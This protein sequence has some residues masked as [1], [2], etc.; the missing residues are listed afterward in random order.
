MPSSDHDLQV[1]VRHLVLVHVVHEPGVVPNFQVRQLTHHVH[2]ALH[3]GGFPEHRWNQDSVLPVNLYHLTVVVGPGQEFPLGTVV[4]RES[5]QL[6]FQF[7][8]HTFIG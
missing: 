6:I 1:V 8:P 4:R 7:S 2:V 5:G 3:Q